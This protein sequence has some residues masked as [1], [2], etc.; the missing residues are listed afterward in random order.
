LSTERRGTG[1]PVRVVRWRAAVSMATGVCDRVRAQSEV[2]KI[3]RLP[4]DQ[5]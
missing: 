2:G 3:Q 4:G 5:V 1:D